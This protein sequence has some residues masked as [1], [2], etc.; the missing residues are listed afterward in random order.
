MPSPFPCV[1]VLSVLRLR[2]SACIWLHSRGPCVACANKRPVLPRYSIAF[3]APCPSVVVP[4]RLTTMALISPGLTVLLAAIGFF[5]IVF[6]IWAIHRYLIP[7]RKISKHTPVP[8]LP[9]TTQHADPRLQRSLYSDPNLLY[10]DPRNSISEY[11]LK[12]TR[13]STNVLELSRPPSPTKSLFGSGESRSRSRSRSRTDNKAALMTSLY[14]EPG[15]LQHD[16]RSASFNLVPVEP[17]ILTRPPT[18]RPASLHQSPS[19]SNMSN[20]AFQHRNSVPTL[21]TLRNSL[22]SEN[23]PF[24]TPASTTNNSEDDLGYFSSFHKSASQPNFHASSRHSLL[25]RGYFSRGRKSS[26]NGSGSNTPGGYMTP[27]GLSLNTAINYSVPLQPPDHNGPSDTPVPPS[28]LHVKTSSPTSYEDWRLESPSHPSFQPGP[29]RGSLPDLELRLNDRPPPRLTSLH[30]Q[31]SSDPAGQT[32]SPTE[33][34]TGQPSRPIADY[35]PQTP[36][37]G[38]PISPESIPA[39][40]L[41]SDPIRFG[42]TEAE[43]RRIQTPTVRT[44]RSTSGETGRLSV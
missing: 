31:P 41:P 40:V 32:L 5:F 20:K 23:N 19:A 26:G 43:E 10:K 36:A 17:D 4:A 15:L 1:C 3:V 9:Q 37:L 12:N 11:D 7:Y 24:L 39:L 14:A 22:Y 34:R 21:A 33:S 35:T 44:V 27:G 18:S 29:R 6:A 42:S 8:T 2:S 30:R 16:A 25:D 38:S 13:Y 28:Y